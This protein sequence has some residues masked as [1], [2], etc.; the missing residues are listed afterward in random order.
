MVM[1][2]LAVGPWERY[3]CRLQDGQMATIMLSEDSYRQGEDPIN[4]RGWALQERAPSP[5][6][7]EFSTSKVL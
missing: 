3:P 4:A 6:H 1:F 2:K 5:R 7:L